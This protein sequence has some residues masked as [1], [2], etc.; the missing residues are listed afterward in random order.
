HAKRLGSSLAHG[1][2]LARRLSCYARCRV[3]EQ[4]GGVTGRSDP[5]VVRD[6]GAVLPRARGGKAAEAQ[7]C[8]VGAGDATAVGEIAERAAIVGGDLPLVGQRCVG[9][10]GRDRKRHGARLADGGGGAL[11]LGGDRWSLVKL[12]HRAGPVGAA[13][14]GRAEKVAAAA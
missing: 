13:A 1:G 10:A 7:S 11:R 12:K 8:R 3:D 4:G 5:I 2:R 6:K 14:V 9:T